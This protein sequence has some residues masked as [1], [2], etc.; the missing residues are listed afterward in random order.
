M[1]GGLIYRIKKKKDE[2]V[3]IW[4]R[5]RGFEIRRNEEKG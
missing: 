4:E 2:E 3:N 5:G 1:R